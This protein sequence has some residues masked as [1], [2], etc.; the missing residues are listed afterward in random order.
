[1]ARLRNSLGPLIGYHGCDRELAEKV[2]SNGTKLQES[3]NKHDWLGP[4][5]YFWV[6]SW[7]RGMQWA[8]ELKQRKKTKMKDPYVIGAYIHPGLCLNLTDYGA[9]Q[10]LKEA[11]STLKTIG[12]KNSW[13]LP[14]NKNL[15]GGVLVE[16]H[17][18]CAVI[19]ML[20]QV[21]KDREQPPYDSVLGMFEEGDELFE[22]SGFREKTHI[23]IAVRP[24]CVVGYFRVP[25]LS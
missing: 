12:E 8:Q 11:Y 18:D 9:L 13:P 19:N 17:L 20:H 2:L 4:G 16:R 3:E 10:E 23:Q 6:D 22:G 7:E 21:R 24:E 5:I 15:K 14:T 1:M 25:D